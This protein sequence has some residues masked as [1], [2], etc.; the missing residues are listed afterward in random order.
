MHSK[1]AQ[2]LFGRWYACLL[3]VYMVVCLVASFGDGW[4]QVRG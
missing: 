2:G 4:Y 1:P 3:L